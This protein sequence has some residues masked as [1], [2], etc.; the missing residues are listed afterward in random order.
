MCQGCWINSILTHFFFTA[1]FAFMFL[2][3]LHTYSILAYV[4]KKDGLLTNAQNM[5][6]GWGISI[7]IVCLVCSL[8]YE[9][10]GGSYHCWLQ[11]NTNLMFG[12]MIPIAGLFILTLTL[13]EAAG[14]NQFRKL[15]GAKVEQYLSGNFCRFNEYF[16]SS[17]LIFVSHLTFHKCVILKDLISSPDK[18]AWTY[19]HNAS[20]IHKF[21]RWYTG[22]AWT[23]CRPFW[24][25][26]NFEWSTG[27]LHLCVALRW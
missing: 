15:P 12:Q 11:V 26:Y 3:S 19:H 16:S 6:V 8:Y 24:N 21:Y 5:V 7:A 23:R 13:I 17:Y 9:D 18:S 2:E 20:C 22:P 27:C 10:Y 1:C 14:A 25:L 4:V